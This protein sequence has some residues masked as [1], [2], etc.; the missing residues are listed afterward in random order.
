MKLNILKEFPEE[1]L[2]IGP[3]NI[4]EILGGPTLFHLAGDGDDALFLS[5]LLHANETSSFFVLQRLIK[6]Y[7]NKKLPRT[8]IVFVGNTYAAAES[9]RHLPGQADFNR[10]WEE[11][12]AA[13]NKMALDV[14]AY[15]KEN[16]LFASI[17]IHNNTG[18]N[19]LYGCVN[20][21]NEEF[22]NLASHFGE[23]TVYFTEPHN[24]QSMAFSK[25]CPST[26]IEAGLPG[27]ETGIE[28]AFKFVDDILKAKKLIRNP[29]R[30]SSEVFHTIARIKVSPEARVDFENDKDSEADL[31]FH[32]NIDTQNFTIIPKNTHVG[33]A[34]NLN[35]VW[36]EANDGT[37]ITDEFLK[38]VDGELLT[39]RLFI[40]SMFT[41][42]IYVMKEDCLGYVMET[43]ST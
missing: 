27:S 15:A 36:V 5:I 2:H 4:H 11:G 18:K 25:I 3:K 14:I 12:E 32:S 41:K 23:H 22:L 1:L 13:E 35:L 6:K 7:K 17:D 8:L 10:I 20:V 39:N 33:Y 21:A 9:M 19:P 29:R 40:P 34:K 26:T 28:A 30:P 38:I 24:V 31:S 43:M 37:I 16:N 42:D